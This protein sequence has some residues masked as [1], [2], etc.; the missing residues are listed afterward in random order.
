MTTR[1]TIILLISVLLS[2]AYLWRWHYLSEG[3]VLLKSRLPYSE[4]RPRTI[5]IR[6]PRTSATFWDVPFSFF[7]YDTH[8]N[9][10]ELYA[11]DERTLFSSQTY[12]TGSGYSKTATVVWEKSGGATVYIDGVRAMVMDQYGYWHEPK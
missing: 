10:C 5:I 8:S 3:I 1:R 7:P 12:S 11:D 2:Y 9:R 6:K 4:Y